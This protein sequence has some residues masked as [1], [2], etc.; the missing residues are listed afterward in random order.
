MSGNEH[1]ELVNHYYKKAAGLDPYQLNHVL[2]LVVEHA[3]SKLKG[4]DRDQ[5]IKDLK[6]II[7]HY[8]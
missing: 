3:L 2:K 1:D 6:Q 4:A 8:K 5:A 7:K